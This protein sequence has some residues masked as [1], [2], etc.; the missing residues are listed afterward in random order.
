MSSVD[1]DFTTFMSAGHQAEA[2]SSS[3]TPRV[4]ASRALTKELAQYTQR[5]LYNLLRMTPLDWWRGER[6]R[7][8]EFAKVARVVLAIPTT[9][10]PT[11]RVFSKLGRV[12]ARKRAHMNCI[13][14]DALMFLASNRTWK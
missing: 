14:A 4:D 12:Y 7:F 11:E 5:L 1:D 2:S 13:M 6:K 9:S 3:G 8:P 10:T